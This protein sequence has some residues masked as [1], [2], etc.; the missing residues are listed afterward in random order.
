MS[1]APSFSL[2]WRLYDEP[3][4]RIKINGTLTD[5][6]KLYGGTRQGCCLSLTLFALFIEQLAQEIGQNDEL[7]GITIAQEEHK[8]ELFAND[9]ITCL[10]NPDSAFLKLLSVL[11]SF[12]LKSGYKLNIY[13]TKVLCVNYTPSSFIRQKYKLKWDLSSINILE[14]SLRKTRVSSMK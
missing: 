8:L 12:D 11:D 3:T 13:K 14:F 5:N 2:C 9:I 1:A 7:T 10:K 4:A 6:L